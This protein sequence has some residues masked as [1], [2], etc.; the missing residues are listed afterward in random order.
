[1]AK[2]LD[3]RL[4]KPIDDFKTLASTASKDSVENKPASLLVSLGKA[5]GEIPSSYSGIHMAGIS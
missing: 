5:L 3:S 4:A 1:M 2:N